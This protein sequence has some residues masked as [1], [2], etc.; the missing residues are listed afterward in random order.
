M[1]TPPELSPPPAWPHCHPEQALFQRG[2]GRS[3]TKGSQE[4]R[5]RAHPR[6]G[7]IRGH[8]RESLSKREG[9]QWPG[10]TWSPR[11]QSNGQSAPPWVHFEGPPGNLSPVPALQHLL[12]KGLCHQSTGRR[13][14]GSAP[15]TM[16][17]A[18]AAAAARSCCWRGVPCSALGHQVPQRL[19]P[20]QAAQNAKAPPT[21]RS[22][23][24]Q[25]AGLLLGCTRGP[26]PTPDW[27]VLEWGW[28]GQGLHAPQILL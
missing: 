12:V 7:Q 1:E 3:G 21:T 28:T 13:T 22:S 25:E 14:W 10:R 23:P 2:T 19:D 27:P 20:A 15:P 4:Q 11:L 6:G 26:K 5:V 18:Q 9:T 16:A 8:S 17:S 24:A